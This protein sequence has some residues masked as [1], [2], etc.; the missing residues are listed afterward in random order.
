MRR[1]LL[2][3]VAGLALAVTAPA[4]ALANGGGKGGDGSTTFGGTTVE[5]GVATLVSNTGNTSTTDDYSG[6]TVPLPAGLTL[7]QITQLSAEYNV[8]DDDCAGGSPRFAINYGPNK[9]VFVYFGPSPNFTG[10]AQN[11]WSSTGNLVGTADS[12]R[13]DTSQLPG[14][15]VNSTWAQAIALTGTQAIT[16]ISLV[17][18]GSWKF[19]DKEQTV[20]VRNVKLNDKTYFAPKH[21]KPV[22]P[23]PWQLCKTQA[24]AIGSRSAFQALWG[25]HGRWNAHGKCT[26]AMKKS[27]NPT[28]TQEQIL[29]AIASCKAEGL[30]GTAL[31]DCVAARD[32]VAATPTERKW[33]KH[34]SKKRP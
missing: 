11:T 8:T 23:K 1:L 33:K 9:N 2:T 13:V 31:G 3:A 25:K 28:A 12:G 34:K 21:T 4:L 32:G 14:G 6:V 24:A 18:D 15:S 16:S 5:K 20:L 30:Q 26:S 7:A 22:K 29:A 19:T 27:P 17:V 10:C